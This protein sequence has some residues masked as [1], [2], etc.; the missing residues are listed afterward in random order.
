MPQDQDPSLEDYIIGYNYTI[1]LSLRSQWRNTSV[2]TD[3][4]AAVTL[5][6]L[7]RV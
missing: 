1:R 7:D 3:T 6:Y 4:L 5:N 2:P